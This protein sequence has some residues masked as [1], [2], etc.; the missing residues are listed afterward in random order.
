[1]DSRA[2]VGQVPITMPL[3]SQTKSA[4]PQQP[5]A[6]S[7]VTSHCKRTSG[8]KHALRQQAKRRRKN[9]TIA[10][11]LHHANASHAR[12]NIRSLPTQNYVAQQP[13]C[14]MSQVTPTAQSDE[15]EK[16]KGDP[17]V[18]DLINEEEEVVVLPDFGLELDHDEDDI[19][20]T[21]ETEELEEV[22][23]GDESQ[24][25]LYGICSQ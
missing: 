21:E 5:L 2:T 12:I 1:M 23:D 10:A 3:P 17:E 16:S 9:T 8:S 6:Q 22:E 14:T 11:G 18:I 13:Y 7:S 19:E 4:C 24:H 20:E 15:V 25:L